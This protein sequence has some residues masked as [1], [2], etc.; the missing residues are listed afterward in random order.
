MVSLKTKYKIERLMGQLF[1]TLIAV[2]FALVTLE[3]VY[4]FITDDQH[5]KKMFPLRTVFHVPKPYVMFTAK[6]NLEGV[7]N[8]LGYLGELPTKI[9]PADEIRIFI[10]GSSVLFN[11]NPPLPRML[12]KRFEKAGK[13]NIKVFNFGIDSSV[14]RQDVARLL[15]DIAG[16]QPDIVL[17][18]AGQND[19][20]DAG[21]DPRINYP[22]RFILYESHPAFLTDVKDYKW[23][24]TIAL[25]SKLLRDIFNYKIFTS[26]SDGIVPGAFPPRASI[27]PLLA[28]AYVQNLRLVAMI[29]RDLGAD[30]LAI[31]PPSLHFKISRTTNELAGFT[32]FGSADGQE[33]KT[34][35]DTETAKYKSE[36]QFIN[37]A[38]FFKTE[39]KEVFE[40]TFHLTQNG[41]R[42]VAEQLLPL[43]DKLSVEH[44]KKRKTNQ[45]KP[46]ITDLIPEEEFNL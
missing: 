22:H 20:F 24:P 30:F 40:D 33:I 43:L 1:I 34:L 17:S 44:L 6:P 5:P 18:Y 8:P 12:Q 2:L 26:L 28:K 23:I 9:K 3:L 32:M 41:N 27:R 19:M 37:Y 31:F 29:S 25:G 11:G 35:V 13:N 16:Y 36:F 7:T 15:F 4:R 10:L 14:S 38:E 42:A 45:I 21:I 46:Q 39:T